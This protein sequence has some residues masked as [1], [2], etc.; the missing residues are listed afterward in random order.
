MDNPVS[1]NDLPATPFQPVLMVRNTQQEIS[2]QTRDA[3]TN[4]PFALLVPTNWQH[5]QET[6]DTGVAYPDLLQYIS[7]AGNTH[8]DW[9]L[10][11]S[12][13]RVIQHLD[14]QW[15]WNQGMSD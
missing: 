10:R 13:G 7:S 15:Q 1:L 14:H 6:I 8:Q 12:T 4:L 5:P 2:L 3:Q 9:Y 11:P